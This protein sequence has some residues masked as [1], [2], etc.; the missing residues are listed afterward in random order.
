M[1]LNPNLIQSDLVVDPQTLFNNAISVV[2]MNRQMR[3]FNSFDSTKT[4]TKQVLSESNHF[5]LNNSMN[6]KHINKTK[7]TLKNNSNTFNNSPFDVLKLL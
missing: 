2:L 6:N 5:N 4:V 1:C 3:K 7:S